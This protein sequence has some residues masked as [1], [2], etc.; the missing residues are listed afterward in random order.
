MNIFDRLFADLH[1]QNEDFNALTYL[2]QWEF[3]LVKFRFGARKHF[4]SIRGKGGENSDTKQTP[5]VLE[6]M[7]NIYENNLNKNKI[8][9]LVTS[10]IHA[11]AKEG[12]TLSESMSDI[13]DI[14]YLSIMQSL[15][16][17]SSTLV[18]EAVET[19]TANSMAL[20]QSIS[21]AKKK[22]SIAVVAILGAVYSTQYGYR[23]F[24][25]QQ[26]EHPKLVS[27]VPVP[28]TLLKI[29]S[30]FAINMPITLF[31]CGLIYLGNR[32]VMLN[33]LD[34]RRVILDKY[35]PPAILNRYISSVRIFT[36]LSL[37]VSI[38]GKQTIDALKMILENCNDYEKIH[39]NIMIERLV[40]G[41]GGTQQLDTGLLS[42]DISL[43]LRMASE[44]ES[45]TVKTALI[46]LANEG[47]ESLLKA[48]DKTSSVIMTVG[49][50]AA[51]MLVAITASS[52]VQIFMTINL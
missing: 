36:S 39:V 4:L 19:A 52:A 34:D 25:A 28:E 47:R 44:G 33:I 46:I 37:L 16:S 6:K 23:Y 35:Y 43:S 29:T 41:E 24:L 8:S 17:N 38:I 21:A 9:Y 5:D 22:I 13:F 7:I 10:L 18:A 26:L 2:T 31:L 14:S 45:A 48:V 42:E 40:Q 30:F 15:E 12:Y 27:L 51:G 49:V 50:L 11:R 3:F 20:N 32:W 1:D